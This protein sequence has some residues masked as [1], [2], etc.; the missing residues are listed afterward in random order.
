MLLANA[1]RPARLFVALLTVEP[2]GGCG[3]GGGRCRR[4][5]WTRAFD[6]A[7]SRFNFST[8]ETPG[9]WRRVE[10]VVSG[11][12]TRVPL[13]VI[14]LAAGA[15][16]ANRRR[17]QSSPP[18]GRRIHLVNFWVPSRPCLP[19]GM[20]AAC[21]PSNVP[22]RINGSQA[23]RKNGLT[24]RSGSVQPASMTTGVPSEGDPK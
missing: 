21:P 8:A 17:I 19:L 10:D 2:G 7:V 6:F 20:T 23:V 1:S 12:H 24:V 13:D 14:G 15:G 11:R 9:L 5:G 4:C 16:I 22:R 3:K 18:S